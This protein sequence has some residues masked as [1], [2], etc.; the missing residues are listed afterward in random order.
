MPILLNLLFVG[1]LFAMMLALQEVG[2]RAALRDRQRTTDTGN[3]ASGAAEA[4]VYALLGLLVAFT[5]SGAAERFESRRSLIVEEAN[6]IGAA[7]RGIELIPAST[8]EPLRQMLRRY[9]DLRIEDSRTPLGSADGATQATLLQREIWSAAAA[10]A[11]AAGDDAPSSVLLPALIEM[12]DLRTLREHGRWRH[13]PAAVFVMLG[14]LVLVAALFAG[15]D[16]AAKPRH[17]TRTMGFSAAL[18]VA[19]FVIIDY[20]FPQIGFIRIDAESALIDVRRV[21]D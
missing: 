6:A 20:E 13:P 2:R 7:W 14:V 19:I 17:W 18:G 3:L 12:F 21:M 1:V 16:I 15:Y 9:A 11:K 10:G 8:Q 4:A 5:F